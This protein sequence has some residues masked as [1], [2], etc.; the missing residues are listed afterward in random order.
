MSLQHSFNTTAGFRNVCV[1]EIQVDENTVNIHMGNQTL[2]GVKQIQPMNPFIIQQAETTAATQGVKFTNGKASG[3]CMP[4][5]FPTR[6]ASL[7]SEVW[8]STKYLPVWKLR[9]PE[10]ES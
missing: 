4:L 3:T 6:L 9:H 8:N 5:P 2:K 7:L 1:D 10:T